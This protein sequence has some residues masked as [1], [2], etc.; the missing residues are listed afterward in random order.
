M[1]RD[2]PWHRAPP[3]VPPGDGAEDLAVVDPRALPAT[4]IQRLVDVLDPKPEHR[5]R[6]PTLLRA[7]LP[8]LSLSIAE[9]NRTLDAVAIID[10]GQLGSLLDVF[11]VERRELGKLSSHEFDEIAA[12]QARA[13]WDMLLLVA[14]RF[15]T[16]PAL[17]RAWLRRTL[18]RCP[19]GGVF[20][21]RLDALRPAW[22]MSHAMARWAYRDLY[23]RGHVSWRD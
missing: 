4:M 13:L 12:L 22:W 20:R 10:D 16:S 21:R 14:D 17:E 7:L 23:D 2:E 11:A 19:K 18:R 6:V 5:P 1:R 3:P 15:A 8:S 9:K